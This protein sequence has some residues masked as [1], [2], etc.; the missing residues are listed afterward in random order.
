M[1]KVKKLVIG[2]W[3]WGDDSLPDGLFEWN[4][5]EALQKLCEALP[6]LECIY[7]STN[8][9]YNSTMDVYGVDIAFPEALWY[10][11]TRTPGYKFTPYDFNQFLATAPIIVLF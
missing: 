1:K 6:N 8:D 5:Q 7:A 2:N 11:Q 10:D 3:I 9:D 4:H